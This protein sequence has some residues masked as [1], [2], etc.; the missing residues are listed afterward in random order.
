[1]AHVYWWFDVRADIVVA[2]IRPVE[3]MS[4]FL[5]GLRI[6]VRIRNLAMAWAVPM[7]AP[8]DYLTAKN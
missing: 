4:N 8:R 1:M 5:Y 2:T 3:A 7:M 6:F